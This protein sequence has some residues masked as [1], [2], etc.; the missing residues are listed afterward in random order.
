MERANSIQIINTCMSLAQNGIPVYLLVR[1]MPCQN[2][3]EMLGFYGLAPHKNLKIIRVPAINYHNHEFIWNKSFYV[4]AVLYI[5]YFLIFKKINVLFLRDLGIAGL[6]LKLRKWFNCK[7]VYE[8]HI[9][10]YIVAQNQNVLF[11]MAEAVTQSKVD[12]IKAK[13]TYVYKNSD[14]LFALTDLLK[15]R[16]SAE[17]SVED[18]KI[19]VLPDGVNPKLF[20]G[21]DLEK[22]EGL[23]YIGQLYPWKG[24]DT[25]IEAMRYIDA[26]LTVIGGI[27]FEDDLIR[28]KKK[29]RELNL[30]KKITF[31]GFIKPEAISEYTKK[32]KI[33][34]IPLT[35]NVIARDFT[36]PLKLFESMASKTAV[37]ASGL[38]SIREVIR[39]GENGLLFEP[40]NA[41]SL[42]EKINLL[43]DNDKLL[44]TITRN[45][46]ADSQK[47]TWNQRALKII[48]VLNKIISK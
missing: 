27:D 36:S 20:S 41:Q 1:R 4:C 2:T 32:A 44:N 33:S 14:A 8:I 3:S 5:I 34:V 10:S 40:G 37:V 47:Y 35:D 7:I 26:K 38:P 17:F 6:F 30:D 16:I 18:G 28:L 19:Y 22:R 23:I 39:D 29:S 12:L 21:A 24:V 9:I 13:E 46:Y 25:L 42:A 43:L 15:Q 31:T 45:A 11:P 48:S